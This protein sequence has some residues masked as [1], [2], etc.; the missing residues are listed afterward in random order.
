MLAVILKYI[1][2]YRTYSVHHVTRMPNV[3]GHTYFHD[4]VLLYRTTFDDFF[5]IRIRWGRQFLHIK[6][7]RRA[8]GKAMNFF[9]LNESAS[10]Q[11]NHACYKIKLRRLLFDWLIVVK[12]KHFAGKLLVW[13]TSG[14][15]CFLPWIF[16]TSLL[17]HLLV[18]FFSIHFL[19]EWQARLSR[20]QTVVVW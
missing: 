4:D 8:A 2:W 10:K 7:F 13:A 5:N 19:G 15:P 9:F 1:L 18:L 3:L 12:K 6:F 11:T 16:H 14:I 17:L 20:V